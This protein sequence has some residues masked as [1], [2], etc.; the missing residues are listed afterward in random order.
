MFGEGTLSAFID[1]IFAGILK[2]VSFIFEK[3]VIIIFQS[4]IV[5]LL[6]FLIFVNVIAIILMKKD[7][8]YAQ[9]DMQRIKESTLLTIA[10]VG[11]GFGEYYAMYKYKHKTMHKKFLYG[12]PLAIMVNIALVTH[13]I[14]TSILA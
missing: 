1:S 11:G 9:K 6:I 14:V 4:R 8:E 7:K 13:I 12:V 10:L 3:I 2:C 5:A